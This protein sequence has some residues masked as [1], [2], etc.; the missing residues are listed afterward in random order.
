VT[1]NLE[2]IVFDPDKCRSELAAFKKLLD[3]KK[4]LGERKHIQRFFKRRRQLSAFIGTFD[5]NLGPARLLAFEFPFVGDFSADIVLGNRE[6]STFCVVEFEDGKSNSIFKK[7]RNKSMTEWSPRFEHGFS[8][9]VDWC[10]TLDDFKHTDRFARDFGHGHVR[11]TALLVLGRNAGVSEHDR[12]RLRGEL[13]RS[14]WIRTPSN[15]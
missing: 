11:F 9:L 1:K 10:C 7:V 8:Q 12:K 5:V 13:R 2:A 14:A 15:A 3:S 6:T 4:D